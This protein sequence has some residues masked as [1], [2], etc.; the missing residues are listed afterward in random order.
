MAPIPS[1][2][3]MQTDQLETEVRQDV[4][5]IRQELPKLGYRLKKI[6]KEGRNGLIFCA[7][8]ELPGGGEEAERAIAYPRVSMYQQSGNH[9]LATQVRQILTVAE[10]RDEVITRVYVEAGVSGADS[11]RPAFQAM[12]RDATHGEE[13]G[14]NYAA[15]ICYDLYRIYRSLMG[16]VNSYEI[17][18]EQG[19]DLVSAAAKDTDLNSRFGKLLM[20]LRGIM[21]EMYLDDLSRTVTDNKYKRAMEGYSNASIAPFGYCRGN[22]FQCTDNQGAG[23]C[24]RFGIR[25]DLWRALGDD[26]KVF[27]PHPIDRHAFGIA[28]DLHVTGDFSDADIARRLSR[29]FP[30]AMEQMN[31]DNRVVV[32][33]LEEGR[34]IVQLEDDTFALQHPGGELQFFRPQGRPGCKDPNRRFSKDTIRDMLQNP[35]YAGFVVYRQ[36]QKVRGKREQHHKR[37]KSPLSEMSRR[38]RGDARLAGEHGMLFPGLHIPLIEVEQFERSQQVRGLKGYNPSNATYTRRIYPLSGVLKCH[39]CGETFR[40]NAGNGDVRYYEDSGVARGI[41]DCPQR[42]FKAN[43]IEEV[44]FARVNQLQIP[45]AWDAEILPFLREGPEWNELRRERLAVQSRLSAGRE[46]LKDD[47]LSKGE[48]KELQRRCERRLESLEREVHTD[49]E[50]YCALLRYFSRLWKA[51]TEEERKG[52]IRCIFLNIWLKDG[53]VVGYDVREPFANFFPGL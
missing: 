8:Y 29:P 4:I 11:R 6:Y 42:M 2:L 39:R 9:S 12:M 18:S 35:Y 24:P 16:L 50:R 23:Y 48:F 13:N 27:V 52:I 41:S 45:E 44:V 10:E 51:A 14:S 49:D 33:P 47:I 1:L 40:G 25:Q 32:E 7:L 26:P 30:D 46:M 36:Q 5:E 31:L 17:L 34:A 3:S 19:I 37:F 20:Y 21:G 15:V 38:E 43:Q 28:T 22:C 53:E